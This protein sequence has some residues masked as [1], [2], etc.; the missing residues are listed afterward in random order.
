MNRARRLAARDAAFGDGIDNSRWVVSYAD[1]ITLL[2]GFFVVMY[3]IS[4][5]ND[6]K[7]RVLSETMV[8]VFQDDQNYEPSHRPVPID[9]GGGLPTEEQ[10]FAADLE[11]V[12]LDADA[13]RARPIETLDIPSDATAQERV[14]AAIGPEIEISDIK[15]RDG[16]HWLEVELPGEML[17]RTGLAQLSD[18]ARAMMRR[19]AVAVSGMETPIRVEGYTDDVPIRGGVFDSN[20]QLSAARA[21]A[22]VNEFSGQGVNPM[23]L[24]AVGFGEFHPIA[25][26]TT[27]DGR[28]QNRRVVVAIAKHPD[29]AASGPVAGD[30]EVENLEVE[31]SLKNLQRVTRLPAPARIL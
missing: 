17:F 29:V 31:I 28:R 16:Q 3:S 11:A 30:A 6:G 14:Q 10:A 26:N 8:T 7:F 20:W 5:V 23:H 4:S 25:D 12:A 2:L 27:D 13:D 21:A 15:I 22:V 1:F 18:E 24:S 19:M 9:L